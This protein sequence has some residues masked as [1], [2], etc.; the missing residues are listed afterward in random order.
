MGRERRQV[1]FP[2]I[3]AEPKDTADGRLLLP[4]SLWHFEWGDRRQ[5]S[6]WQPG[7][8]RLWLYL[9]VR[10]HSTCRY[11]QMGER[12]GAATILLFKFKNKW[13]FNHKP[14]VDV[15]QTTFRFDEKA[16]LTLQEKH[17]SSENTIT[18]WNGITRNGLSQSWKRDDLAT[19]SRLFL[20]YP[21][22]APQE[23]RPCLVLLIWTKAHD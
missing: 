12:R 1:P 16:F 9:K 11:L 15:S 21:R 14:I 7:I 19:S 5:H 23:G 18:H 4:E 20:L 8:P 13:G 2:V 10:F 17:H 3:P 22:P 6:H